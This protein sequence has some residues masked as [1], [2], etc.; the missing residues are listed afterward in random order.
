[1]GCLAFDFIMDRFETAA[2]GSVC[3]TGSKT[4]NQIHFSSQPNVIAWFAYGRVDTQ[5]AIRRHWHIHENV[6]GAWYLVGLD[7]VGCKRLRQ[8]AKAAA[9][10]GLL[11]IKMPEGIFATRRQQ[12][13][14]RADLILDDTQHSL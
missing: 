3:G 8:V 9:V 2:V 4:Y 6:E 5:R 11:G 7:P 1:M 10:D 13:I 12:K 14:M